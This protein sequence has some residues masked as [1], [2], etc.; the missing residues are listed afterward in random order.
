[1]TEPASRMESLSPQKRAL[2]AKLLRQKG[3]DPDSLPLSHAQERLWFLD[4]LAPGN[5]FYNMPSAVRMTGRLD[6]PALERSLFEI[7]RRHETLRTRFPALAGRPVQW[8]GG[9]GPG[10]LAMPVID[11]GALPPESARP[12]ADRLGEEEGRLPF[13]LAEGPVLRARLLRLGAEEHVLLLTLHHIVAD[14]WSIGVLVREL[15]VLYAAFTLGE[16]PEL[17]ELPIQYVDF[18]RWQRRWLRGEV[19]DRQMGYWRERLADLPVL[20][21][22]ADRRRPQVPRFR[23]ARHRIALPAG[24]ARGLRRLAQEQGATPFM[25]LL[26]AFV[27][28]LH[29][30]SN[31]TDFAVGTPIANR[32]RDEV[33]RLIGFFVNSLVLRVDAAGDPAFREL[34]ARVREVALGA[35]A[36]QDLPFEKIVEEIQPHRDPSTNPLFQV[37]FALQNAPLS[38]L[39]LPGLQVELLPLSDATSKFDL[40]LDLWEAEDGLY[41][42]F[43]YDTDLFEAATVE[44]LAGHFA[45]LVEGAARAPETRLQDLPLLG[46]A[47]RRALVSDWNGALPPV[48]GRDDLVSRFRAQV[49]RRTGETAVVFE[50]ESLT[51]GELERRASRFAAALHRRGV[52]EGDLVGVCLERSLDL[53]VAILGVLEAGGAYVPLDPYYPEDR[54]SWILADSGARWLVDSIEE[55]EPVAIPSPSAS[56]PAYVIYTSG[57]TGRP[58]G[59]VVTHGHAT[60]LFDAT[61]AWF[62]FGERDV[63]TLFHSYAFDFSVWELWGALLYG[64]RLVV[65]PYWV[66]RSPE[67]FHALLLEQSVTVLNQTPSAFR[68]LLAVESERKSGLPAIREVIFGGEALEPAMLKPWWDAG[69]PGRLVNMYGITET[70]VHVTYRP[71]Q[72]SDVGRGSRIGVPI[73]DLRVYVVSPGG[74]LAPIGVPGEL[75]VGGAGVSRGYLGGPELTAER[76]V[77]DAWSGVPGARIYRSGDLGRWTAAGDL[78]Y[79]GRI[80]HQVKIRGFRIEPGE[81]EAAALEHPGVG[82]VAV[83][84]RDQGLVAYVVPRAGEEGNDKWISETV[85]RWRD[86]FDQTYGASEAEDPTFNIVGWTSA[87]TGEA[88]PAE[89]MR[90][91][92]METVE[93]LRQLHPRRVLELGCGTGMI[94]FRL[95]P[96][97]ERYCGTDLS[98]QALSYVRGHVERLGL[99]NVELLERGAEDFSGLAE[100]SFNAV[101][102][103]SVAQYFPSAQYLEEVLA[104]AVD[105]VV[106]GGF[107]YVGDVRSLPLL[108]AQHLEVERRRAEPGLPEAQIEQRARLAAAQETELILAPE[109]FF[110]LAKRLPRV[111]AVRIAAKRAQNQNE[112]TKYRYQVVLQVG[113]VPEPIPEVAGPP[114]AYANDPRRGLFARSLVPSLRRQLEQRLPAYMVPS[115]FVMLDALPVTPQGKLDRGALPEPDRERRAVEESWVAPRTPVE[116]ELARIW[117]EVLGV[118]RVG[119]E[120]DFFHLGGHSLL[121]TQVVSQIREKLGVEIPLRRLFDTPALSGLAEGVEEALRQRRGPVAPPIRRAPR[122]GSLPLS[123]AQERLWFLDRLSPGSSAYNEPF[124][125]RL[126][127]DLDADALERSLLEIVR[128]HESLRTVFPEVD[129]RPVQAVQAPPPAA[130][131]RI[132]LSAFSPEERERELHRL[133]DEQAGQGFDLRRGPLLRLALVRLSAR[134]HALLATLH[135]IVFDG[136]STSVLIRELGALYAAFAA[137]RPSPLPEPALQYAD[138]AGWQREWMRGEVLERHLAWWR[139]RLADAQPLELPTD[140]P[141]PALQRFRGGKVE[142]ALPESIA[143]GVRELGQAHGATPFMVLLAGFQT[144]LARLS[145]QRDV[146]VGSPIA[147]RD[148]AETEGM[149]GFFVNLL[150]LRADL[151]AD[152]TFGELVDQVRDTAFSAYA[153]QGLPFEK[154]VDE[155]RLDRDLGRNPLFQVVFQLHNAPQPDLDL[156][157][158]RLRA[159]EDDTGAA[160][161]D[162]DLALVE[163]DGGLA[164]SIDFDLDLFDPTTIQRLARAYERLLAGAIAAPSRRVSELELLGEEDR[165]LLRIEWNDTATAYPRERCVHELFAEQA[166]RRPGAVAVVQGDER[167]TYG[168]LRRRANRLA[169]TLRELGVGPE[170]RVGVCHERSPELIVA[171]LAALEAG[172]AY[173]PFD[174]SLPPERLSLLMRDA[175]PR[176]VLAA[177][178]Q[179]DL[180]PEGPWRIVAGEPNDPGMGRDDDPPA[181]ATPDGLVYVLYTSGS[182]GLPKGVAAVHRAVV[183]LVMETDYVALGPDEVFLQA[184][185][186]GFDASTL[187]LW[188]CLLHGGRLVL[189]PP[190]RPSLAELGA[191]VAK[192]K[193]TTLWLTAALFEQMVAERLDDLR[194]VRQL[195]AGG[196]VLP[197]AQVR[198][199]LAGLAGGVVINGYG[200]TENTTFTC[201]HRMASPEDVEVPVPIG[202]PIANGRVY[203]LD[204]ELRPVALGVAGELCCAGD[205]LARGYWA[206]PDLTAERFV[207]DPFGEPGARMYRTGDRA[208]WLRD[209]R[210]EFLGRL[211]DQVKLRGFRVEPGEVEAALA[212]HPAV[213]QAIV[214]AL[215]EGL[216]DRR[217]VAFVAAREGADAGELRRYLEAKLPSY[218]VPS[219]VMVLGALPR[220][221]QGKVDR[222]ALA[223]LAEERRAPGSDR[224]HVPP[225]TALEELLA[226]IWSE[227]LGVERVGAHDDFFELGGHS[228]LATQLVSRV[229]TALGADLPLRTVFEAPELAEMA[230]AIGTLLAGEESLAEPPL[231]PVEHGDAAS[232][233]NAAPLSFAQER[234]WFLDQLAPGNPFYNVPVAVRMRGRLDVRALERSLEAV[235][236]RHEALRTH[237]AVVDGRPV[238]RIEPFFWRAWRAPLVDLSALPEEA[239]R[240]EA[241]RLSA[242]EA[243]RPFDLERGP[244]VRARLL[245]LAADEH[246]LLV[247]LHHIVSDGWS[248]GVLVREVAALYAAR[249]L[250]PLPVQ[251]PDFAVWQRGWLRG[252]VWG[253]QMRYWVERLT[254]L[255]P[256]E[257]PTDRRRP[258]VQRF[259]GG[260]VPVKLSAAVAQGVRRIGRERSATPFMTLL[261]AFAAL[262]HRWSNQADLAVGTPIANRNRAEIE[263]LIGFFVNS[264]VLRLDLAGDPPFGE[265]VSRVREAALGAYAHQDLPFEKLVEE[266]QPRRDTSQNPLFQVVFV[267]QNAPLPDL[268]L[269]GLRL[270]GMEAENETSLF[271]LKL[272]LWESPQGLHGAFRYDTDLF[273]AA[274]VERMADHFVRLMEG[275]AAETRLQDLPL[276]GE[277]ERRALV[278]DWNGALPPVPGRDDLVSRFRAQAERRTGETAVVFEAESLT[279]GELERRA[280][281]LAAALHRRGVREGDLVGVCLERSLDLV[282]AILGVLEAG[283]AYVPLDPYYPEDR[284]SWILADSG[285]RW[286]VDSIEEAEPLEIPPPSASS[287]AYVIYTSGSTGRPKGVVVTHGHATRLFD[288]TQA[289]FGFGERDVWTLFHSYAF[290][291]SVWELWGALLYGGRLVVVPYWVSRSPESFHA[292]LLEQSVT[293]L[294][295]TPSAFRQLLAVES[296][297][298]S[299]LPSVREVIFGGEALEPAMLKPWWD[300][301]LPGRLVNMYGITETTVHVT[302]RPLQPA[303]VGRGSRIGVPIPDLRVYVV[304][305]GGTLSPIGVPGELWVGGAGVSRGYLGRPELTAERFVPDAWSGAEGARIYRSGDLGRWTAA[306]DLEYLGRIDHQV[307]IRGF[308]IEPG[309]IEAAALEHPGVGQVAVIARDQGLVAY[310]VPESGEEG[311]EGWTLETVSRWRDVFDQTYGASEA[312]DPTF[313]IVGWTSAE[314]GEAIPA[315]E[316]REWLME[317]VED[318]RRLHPRRVLELG[319]GTGMI[320]FR[321]AP[322]AERYCGTDLSGQALSYVRGHVERLRLSNVELLERGAEDFSGLS[323]ESFDAVV[324]NSVAQ[325]FPSAEYLEEVLAQAVAR[326]E[327]GGFV[328]VGDVRSLPLLL[329]QHLE[330]ERRRAE[331]GISEAQIEQRA[332]LA[333]AQET[334]LILAPEF[335]FAL[336]KRLPR[337]TAVRIAAKRA[338]NQNELTKYR[339]QVVLHVGHV[340]GVPETI[341]EIPEITGSPSAYANDPRRGLFARSLV[342]SLRRQLEQRLPAYMVPSAFVML[343]AL[344]VT[345]QGKLDRR[346]LPE[347]DRERRAVE[348]SW[349]APRTPVEEELARIWS[350]VLGVERVG[351]ED[352]F[353]HLG[354][355]SLLATQVVSQIREKLGVEI[356]LRRLFDTPALSGLAEGVEEALRRR[357]G[358]VAPPIRRAPRSGGLPLSFAQER[359]WFLDR[360][361]P[362]SS[363]YNEPFALRLDGGL[364]ADALERALLEIVRRHES[365]R[366]VFPEIDGRPVQAV[367]PPPLA[368][369][370]R[371]DL[372]RI[373]E[374][375][376]ALA[377]LRSEQARQGFDLQRGPLL[378]T[379]LVRLAEREHALLVTLHHIVFDGWSTGVLIRELAALYDAFAA[380]RPSPLPEPSLQ[381]ADFA[382]WQREW[383]QGEV[384]ERHLAWW[385]AHLAGAPALELPTD[386][387][388]PAVQRF[389][390]GQ[391]P[392]A[393]AETT[394]RAVRALARTRGATPFMALLAGFQALLARISGQR[395]VV[396]GSPIANRDRA[397]TEGMIGFFVNVLALRADLTRDPSFGELVEQARETALS[398]YAWQS[399]PFERLVDELR[400]AR[401]LGRNPL[402]QVA[403]QLL[404][405]P[406]EAPRLGG[407]SVRLDPA[408]SGAA[409]FDLD[410]ALIEGGESGA[411]RSGWTGL[412]EYDRDLFDATTVRRLF[413]AYERLLAAGAADPAR[414]V[415]ELDLLD[416][417]ERFQIVTEWNDSALATGADLLHAL[418]EAQAEQRPASFAVESVEG[419]GALTY[420]DLE[421]LSNRLA[422]HLRALGVGPDERVAVCVERS[423]R[424]VAAL[425]GV[426]KAG[427]AY[428]PLDPT[429]P[430]ER[431]AYVLADCGARVLVA[432]DAL[433]PRLPE[434]GGTIVRLDGDAPAIA[435]RVARRPAIDIPPEALAYVLYTSGST[436]RPKGVGVPH[437]A[438][439]RFLAAMR[440]RPGLQAGERLLGVT[441]LSFDIAAL[442]IFLPLAVGGTVVLAG[443]ETVADGERLA[444]A[445][446]SSGA[447]VMQATPSTWRMLRDA[448]WSGDPRLRALCGGEALPPDLAAFLAERCA[449]CWNLYGPTET[450][451]WSAVQRIEPA[452]LN[453]SVSLGRP[454]ANTRVAVLDESGKPAAIGVPGDL[455]LGGDGVARGYLGRPDLTAER[456]VPDPFSERPGARL[457]DTGDRARLRPD[458]TLEFLGRRD[459]QMK[460]RGHRVEAGEIEAALA[461]HPG[462][463]QAVVAVRPGPG[464]E[465]RL[466]AWYV[467]PSEPSPAKLRGRL[468]AALPDYM[469]PS[470]FVRLD[471]FPLTPNGKIDRR[472]LPEPE[473]A[474]ARAVAAAPRT[475]YEEALAGM[476][477]E[478]LGVTGVA[479]SDGFFE[480]GGHSLLA[481]RLLSRVRAT[482]GVELP[483]LRLFEAPTL[484]A[485]AAAVESAVAARHAG[486]TGDAAT[487][488]AIVPLASGEQPP[489]SFAQERLWF[490]DR[491]V[492]DNPFYNM[493]AAV[494]IRGPLAVP[495]LAATLDEIVRRHAALRASFPSE[496]GRPA[497]RIAPPGPRPLPGVDLS[498]LPEGLREATLRA[499]ATGESL[500]PF[501][502][503]RGPVLRAS[504]VRIAAD[505]HVLL[506]TMH[507]I[508]SDG[509]SIGVL[510]RELTAIYGAFAEGRAH[511]LPELP[512]QYHDYA[513]WQRRWLQ[514]E[515]LERQLAYWKRRL[516]GEPPAL[517]LPA[518]RPRPAVQ[519]FHGASRPVAVAAELTAAL[520]AL[521][522]REGATLFMTLLAAYEAL[523]LRLT[524]QRD[525]VVGSPIANRRHAEI[526]DLIGFFV[527]TLALRADLAG[528][529][530]F[531]GLLRRVREEALGAYAH[532]DLP[533]EKL[534]E[535][536]Q[537]E[538]DTSQNPLFQVLFVLQNAPLSALDL[539]GLDLS[540]MKRDARAETARFDLTLELQPAGAGLGGSLQ[541]SRD[542]FDASTV[543]RIAEHLTA[544]LAGAAADPEARLSDL[545]LLGEAARHQLLAE[546]GEGP[547]AP[548]LPSPVTGGVH[549]LFEVQAARTPDAPALVFENERISYREL[550]RRANLLARRLRALGVGPEV[551][552]GLLLERSVE[553]VVAIFGVLKAGGFYVPLDPEYPQERL[554]DMIAMAAAPVVLAG[555]ASAGS[556]EGVLVLEPGW[557]ADQ[558]GDPGDSIE[559]LD[560]ATPAYAIFTSGSTG[561]PKGIVVPHGALVNHMLWMQR[562]FPLSAD[563]AVLQKTPFSFDASVWEFHAPLM[564]GGRLVVARPGGHRDPGYLADV[565]ARE[566]VTI[567]Q[568]VPALLQLLLDE[569]GLARCHRLRRVFCGG[570]A[571]GAALEER[572]FARAFAETELVNLYGPAEACI[573]ST[574]WVCRR[575]EPAL[576]VPIGRPIDGARA[577]VLDAHLRPVP[578]GVPGELCLGGAGLGRGYLGRP[579]LTAE[580]FVPA[581][582]GESGERLYRTGDLVRFLPDG[583]LEFLGRIDGQVKLRGFRVETG[584]IESVLAAHPAV[585]EAVVELRG[586]GVDQRLVAWVVP[587][588]EPA[589]E[590]GGEPVA[591]WQKVFDQTFQA[592]E[593][594]GEETFNIVGWNSSYTGLPIPAPEMREWLDATVERIL[595]LRPRRVLEI[596]C[597]TGLIL[598]RVAPHCERYV[599]TDFSA[600]ALE[601]VRERAGG[602]PQVVLDQ[603]TADDFRGI[604]PGSFDLVILNSVAQ[605]FP[606]VDYLLRVLEGA[607]AAVRAGGHVLAGDLR[608]LPLLPVFHASVQLARAA[609][610]GDTDGMSELH[611]RAA[612]RQAEEKELVIDPALFDALRRQW[613]RVGHAEALLKRGVHRNE[614]TRFRYDAVLHVEPHVRGMRE[615]DVPWITWHEGLDLRS[616]LEEQPELLAVADVPDD[617]VAEDLETLAAFEGDGNAGELR[618]RLAAQPPRG[619][620]PEAVWALAAETGYEAEIGPARSG[621]AGRFDVVLRLRGTGL[622]RPK[623]PE[624]VS[625]PWES[626]TNRPV[627]D[628]RAGRIAAE[629]RSHLKAKLPPY[630]VPSAL[631]VLDELPLNPSGKVDRAALPDPPAVRAAAGEGYVA[632]RNRLEGLIAAAWQEVLGLDA[633]GIHDNFFDLGGHSLRVVQIHER[634]KTELGRELSLIHLFQYPTVASLAGFLSEGQ[635]AEEEALSGVQARAEARR[636]VL[637]QRQQA[638]RGRAVRGS[639]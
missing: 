187:E 370:V 101:V 441:T 411:A 326:V 512:V 470:L 109:F 64:G 438:I 472:A 580:R 578:A 243:A 559:D 285:A 25:A 234:L 52:R 390:G 451:V 201:C 484:E 184:S 118:E 149:I 265:L 153:H 255:E 139:E 461:A 623:A 607:V 59:V 362:G 39:E 593:S 198:A 576:S 477:E 475:P 146:V 455:F 583:S 352:D 369:L 247:T 361:S 569:P 468:R 23:G 443:R 392:V 574:F 459:H 280:S 594:G 328:Y 242:A 210:V 291:F 185:P 215:G 429:Y 283:G 321:L 371:I 204:R 399:L 150:A 151:T 556:G 525:L 507:H 131:P 616:R 416:E 622:L 537:P 33:E 380:G 209:G 634:L 555:V 337:V 116:E 241:E 544:L 301:G 332:R 511:G 480:L 223:T 289:W 412:V 621:A 177:P 93:D 46:E 463:A 148:R 496:Q 368:G 334:E 637:L 67:T 27:A 128:R 376:T 421:I 355:H 408:S 445:L 638:R 295:Q 74:T 127:G 172:A 266:L 13:R 543:A 80:D 434:H 293:V 42:A 219:R 407:L 620:D 327:D 119:A 259:R 639:E 554:A 440:Q 547:P 366:T 10:A 350:E 267:L 196:D 62:G 206:R 403:F 442:E 97:T 129:G 615:V 339:Y 100:E 633:V 36:H 103:N 82:Q 17:P 522:R 228:L 111:T 333:A 275:A 365:L 217:L 269:P 152:P 561:R 508:I 397:E 211:D 373:A 330:V 171:L 143:R 194:G 598:F 515:V 612:R 400:L 562:A 205:G 188:G 531:A 630:M 126:D 539:G 21:L 238:Q 357:R 351:A 104:K 55:A 625:R 393:V 161:F 7:V 582:I 147:N 410:L 456:F 38:A 180:L 552:V 308:R 262:L 163:V 261:A 75:W 536:I 254:G 233:A 424:M 300:A 571:L 6:A 313:N 401:D 553:M 19:W 527:N 453:G 297:R 155:L 636:E 65:V 516:A 524:G 165:F 335:F 343:D 431:L 286:L 306:G 170:D 517:R 137:G 230:A 519:R 322:E 325:Y 457:Y 35:Y 340:G 581:V 563:D 186:I 478:I 298:K 608:S 613:P 199:A 30:W 9:A 538:R 307:K 271:D 499:L 502:L 437:R 506:L 402:F 504:L 347:P 573:D 413:R 626:Y 448:G 467:A 245:R 346:A 22:P 388:R 406:D 577:L 481:T 179:E 246:A 216:G 96:E 105:R 464:G 509:W 530:S 372:S 466:V 572:F 94:L 596:G 619:V 240:R 302:Y 114:S 588:R 287:P 213:R 162:L 545:P 294:N 520:Q 135:H 324:L 503:D 386:R 483:L 77:P 604:D 144:L 317:T 282:V 336:A 173:V 498:A 605:Y 43:Q 495:A 63:W 487:L 551:P 208:R 586:A 284:R 473:P 1:M 602:L 460:V 379:V 433:L 590:S 319:C 51:Y 542:L 227:L 140:R 83:I 513:A 435:A 488:P 229:R 420:G 69:L 34:V 166:A 279:Y 18:A 78:E 47:E 444:A 414:R 338:Q 491:L 141:R 40:K 378:R 462:V 272:D 49:E 252:E 154:L 57:S 375:E 290:D 349:V 12:E 356:P 174:L 342:P 345:P 237:F 486:D 61:Q 225:R 449:A 557:G 123:F 181:A 70:T 353:F 183:R 363:A 409:K 609:H 395:D 239:R 142:L 92:L 398:A 394:T 535:E 566:E 268:E 450:T 157:G 489:L 15:T 320:L 263:G 50:T 72:P 533:F 54:R 160:K 348:E 84:A 193:V 191:L 396:V 331:P 132:D 518:D 323:P 341:P 425:L 5:P 589:A 251:Y 178:G 60:R 218:M 494:R 383:M 305:P 202:R 176:V 377:R 90:E 310:V 558:E 235:A 71:L 138:F 73:P 584:E 550:N 28:L 125:L 86:V 190:D 314:T 288:A 632:P 81:I 175:A 159:I 382:R 292:L 164:G 419:A 606:G 426:L 220:T 222:R 492:P 16:E 299:G 214:L 422:R 167:L 570:E 108:L 112:L 587:A 195:L 568:L 479:P 107:V 250:P 428:V 14:G 232:V 316:M 523:L 32:N 117:S 436:G 546:W 3:A 296:E 510:I 526:E 68:Q 58:K 374:R 469:V 4:Q 145:G 458:G 391:L 628:A 548:A 189:A 124:A 627:Q 304:S 41:G 418:F 136:W 579:D 567:L 404:N 37:V 600:S 309:E 549:R 244:V 614:L 385:R 592:P 87:E 405:T 203:L 253:R 168:E 493:P 534:V 212:G 156:P 182:T 99:S 354:G 485:L 258:A 318:L 274:T 257:L 465:A 597:G 360:L 541:Y 611:R 85:S 226:G 231:E 629:L 29:R 130:L 490:L 89:E 106:D 585:R 381:Y 329:A 256:L 500:R 311:R 521:A 236:E 115:A 192:E 53:V 618:Q 367:Q 91:W 102:L 532:Q 20:E 540:L 281:R 364:D 439:A 312:D 134:E 278:S 358:P 432:E 76:F 24:V 454:I 224:E 344:P 430:A 474:A 635:P 471:T 427:G 595:A 482:F 260:R 98:G 505:D 158:L 624:I 264:L 197:P 207:P 276:L 66:S 277:A 601:W 599:A 389:H 122:S 2:L 133:R 514:G 359:L 8:V 617:R 48:P 11:L 476:W 31:Q 384:L 591:Q 270:E 110:A 575:G 315:E 529:P 169:W 447:R 560:P 564:A 273:D 417:A 44:R 248:V 45:R 565:M 501:D 528:D 446:A 79:L 631:V 249:E 423:P 200:P 113:G 121:A 603:R 120:D 415:S 221:P 303:D 452:A 610:A 88:I 56:S 95:A 497:L 26:A 387:P